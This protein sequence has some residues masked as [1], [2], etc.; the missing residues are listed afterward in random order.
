MSMIRAVWKPTVRTMASSS[1]TLGPKKKKGGKGG[2]GGKQVVVKQREASKD[3]GKLSTHCCGL[4]IWN[5]DFDFG[6]TDELAETFFNDPELK[7]DSE[8]PEWLFDPRL[9]VDM[10][11]IELGDLDME[12]DPELYWRRFELEVEKYNQFYYENKRWL[13]SE[14]K[15][16]YVYNFI[17]HFP[18]VKI[19]PRPQ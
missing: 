5:R 11:A 13:E 3:F 16:P 9:L 15:E 19:K 12:R 6:I 18:D 8:Y 10:D 7:P 4:N 17:S 2:G 1:Q 14:L